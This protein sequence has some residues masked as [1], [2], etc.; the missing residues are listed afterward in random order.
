MALVQGLAIR[1][2]AM[3]VAAL[4][5]SASQAQGSHKGQ[6]QIGFSTHQERTMSVAPKAFWASMNLG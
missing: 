5:S 1:H 2:V 4:V 6:Q 3:L